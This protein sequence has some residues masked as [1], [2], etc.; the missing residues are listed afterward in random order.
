MRQRLFPQP[1]VPD[2]MISEAVPLNVTSLDVV[3]SRQVLYCLSASETLPDVVLVAASAGAFVVVTDTPVKSATASTQM[4]TRC[5]AITCSSTSML[6][7]QFLERTTH[8][9]VRTGLSFAVRLPP[10]PGH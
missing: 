3:F 4:W 8:P 1:Q 10:F 9:Q 5:F 2:Q 6:M 7:N